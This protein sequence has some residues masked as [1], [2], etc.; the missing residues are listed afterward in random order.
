MHCLFDFIQIPLFS[1]DCGTTE[2]SSASGVI[3]S[4]GFPSDYPLGIRCTYRINLG[5]NPTTLQL[6][7]RTIDIE[8]QDECSY[9]SLEINRK[10]ICG[11]TADDILCELLN[12]IYHSFRNTCLVVT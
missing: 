10:L 1:A 4:P 7:F 11:A 2:F 8:F 5:T 9:D 6:K 12:M 3:T